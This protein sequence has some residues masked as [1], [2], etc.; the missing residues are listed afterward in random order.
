MLARSA[1]RNNCP[2]HL[3][4]QDLFGTHHSAYTH[5]LISGRSQDPDWASVL[6]SANKG[7]N[8]ETLWTGDSVVPKQLFINNIDTCNVTFMDGSELVFTAMNI[9]L[10]VLF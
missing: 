4:Y 6:S 9:N 1:S 2:L 8:S 7:T 5:I 3:F 10:L